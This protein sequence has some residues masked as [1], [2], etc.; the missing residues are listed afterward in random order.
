MCELKLLPSDSDIGE[1]QF[2]LFLDKSNL[3]RMH[4]NSKILR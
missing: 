4:I 2:H 3:Y 1:Q